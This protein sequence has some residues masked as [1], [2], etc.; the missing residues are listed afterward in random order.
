MLVDRGQY[1]TIKPIERTITVLQ[2]ERS[3]PHLSD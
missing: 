1:G 3:Q 2:P